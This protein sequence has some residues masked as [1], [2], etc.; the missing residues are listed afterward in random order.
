MKTRNGL[1]SG[2]GRSSRGGGSSRS[3]LG[4][5]AL[6]DHALTTAGTAHAATLDGSAFAAARAATLDGSAF[7]AARAATL[8]GSSVTARAALFGGGSLSAVALPSLVA[9]QQAAVALLGVVLGEQ[10]AV[11]PTATVAAVTGHRA[12]VTADEGDGD[13]REEHRNCKTE[14]P[15]HHR[16]PLGETERVVR[17][18]KPSRIQTRSGTATGPQQAFLF[19]STGIA[20][21]VRSTKASLASR[22][23]DAENA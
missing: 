15:L 2:L 8:D 23:E 7:A 16:P 1:K 18:S 11:A 9:G 13:E 10:T 6:G 5:H 12:R 21:G 17:P 4:R 3:G 22:M 14:E 19:G 20:P